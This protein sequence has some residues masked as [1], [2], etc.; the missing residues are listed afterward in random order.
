M[1][2]LKNYLLIILGI[3]IAII[4]FYEI[5]LFVFVIIFLL[6][7]TILGLYLV[8]KYDIPV[9]DFMGHPYKFIKRF[10]KSKLGRIFILL[11]RIYTGIAVGLLLVYIFEIIR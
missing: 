7:G 4:A 11:S 6:I 1:N 3:I 8:Q 9:G 10:E 2:K 5:L